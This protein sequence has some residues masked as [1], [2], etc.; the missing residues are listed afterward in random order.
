MGSTS[1]FYPRPVRDLAAYWA[2][3]AAHLD[4][5]RQR[6]REE[7]ATFFDEL[8]SLDIASVAERAGFESLFAETNRKKLN[9]CPGISLRYEI[10]LDRV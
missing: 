1:L 3:W 5:L 10:P 4:H 7:F 2:H 8:V 9:V 6:K